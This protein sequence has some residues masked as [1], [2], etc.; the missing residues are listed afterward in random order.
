MRAPVHLLT[1]TLAASPLAAGAQD[2][3]DP[4]A[5]ANRI[6]AAQERP[7]PQATVRLT[8]DGCLLRLEQVTDVEAPQKSTLT[9]WLADLETDPRLVFRGEGQPMSDGVTTWVDRAVIYPWKRDVLER[10]ADGIAAWGATT[11]ALYDDERTPDAAFATVLDQMKDG[12]FGTF[13]QRNTGEAEGTSALGATVREPLD[14]VWSDP[15]V[16]RGMSPLDFTYRDSEIDA[17]LDDLHRYALSACP[18]G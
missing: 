1:L 3:P 4:T 8:F 18:S 14:L 13:F 7:W 17:L 5:L 12:T 10:Y 9:I 16:G 15:S 11:T 6:L 2:A